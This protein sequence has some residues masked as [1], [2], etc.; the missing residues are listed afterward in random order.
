MIVDTSALL[1]IAFGEPDAGR[2]VDAI[3][4]APGAR[5]AA[6]SWVEPAMRDG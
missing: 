6:P 1:A 2:L 4:D 5:M 3:T